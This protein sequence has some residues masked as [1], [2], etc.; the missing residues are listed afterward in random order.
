M[1]NL[2]VH[3]RGRQGDLLP[4]GHKNIVELKPGGFH[5]TAGLLE[6][7]RAILPGPQPLRQRRPRRAG[8]TTAAAQLQMDGIDAN[9]AKKI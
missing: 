7:G 3:I 5:L 4:T 2:L 9:G 1:L 8:A 6:I